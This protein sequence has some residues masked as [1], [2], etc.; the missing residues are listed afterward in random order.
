[1]SKSTIHKQAQV[2]AAG[3][4]GNTEVKLKNRKMLDALTE[5]GQRATEVER[6]DSQ[7]M[8]EVAA[9]RLKVRRSLQK[10]LQVPQPNM[11]KATKAMRKVKVRGTVK[12]MTG[13]KRRSVG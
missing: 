7:K 8:L 13:T 9:R 6:S 12:N 2:K 11:S 10:V 4:G 5:S 3:K 1:M